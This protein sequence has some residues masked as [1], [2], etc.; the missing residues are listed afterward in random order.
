MLLCVVFVII[1]LFRSIRGCKDARRG[2]L[3][4][5][6][7]CVCCVMTVC[8]VNVLLLLGRIPRRA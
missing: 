5:D 8:C 6:G 7:R 3:M 2:C 1:V 4:M